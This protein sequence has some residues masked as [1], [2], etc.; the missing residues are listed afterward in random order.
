MASMLL[1]DEVL[2]GVYSL[3]DAEWFMMQDY[4][5]QYLETMQTI[6]T[7]RR[8]Y[9][10]N[11]GICKGGC[12]YFESRNE[13]IRFLVIPS[14]GSISAEASRYKTWILTNGWDTD[15]PVVE[16]HYKRVFNPA[17]DD[18]F[19]I[20]VSS[21]RNMPVYCLNEQFTRSLL[22]VIQKEFEPDFW[23]KEMG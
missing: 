17:Y 14:S 16:S 2:D 19:S 4:T 12:L 20:F 9:H 6:Y 22:Q 5:D 15:M 1:R 18:T 7:L 11:K 21:K 8:L 3:V 10:L 13:N 23:C